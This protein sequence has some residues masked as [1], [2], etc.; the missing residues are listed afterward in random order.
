MI[1][2]AIVGLVNFLIKKYGGSRT[3]YSDND[4]AHMI[5]KLCFNNHSKTI[6]KCIN[7]A[8]KVAENHGVVLN[9]LPYNG[10]KAEDDSL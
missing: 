4:C 1:L 3:A 2:V 8:E 6:K 5:E 10:E 7:D 9:Y